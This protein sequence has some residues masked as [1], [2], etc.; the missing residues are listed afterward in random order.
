MFF[1]ETNEEYTLKVA[2]T[3]EKACKLLEAGF[4]RVAEMDGKQLFRKRK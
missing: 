2:S 1:A 3:I 4:E